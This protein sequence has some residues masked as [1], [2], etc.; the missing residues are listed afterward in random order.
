M[1]F[2]LE[3]ESFQ[4]ISITLGHCEMWVYNAWK[5]RIVIHIARAKGTNC[6]YGIYKTGSINPVHV[7]GSC[8]RDEAVFLWF[9]LFCCRQA[10]TDR[11]Y[12]WRKL[13][14]KRYN[15]N[16]MYVNSAYDCQTPWVSRAH[17]GSTANELWQFWSAYTEWTIPV[18]EVR[19]E[20]FNF[21]KPYKCGNRDL[22]S[23]KGCQRMGRSRN[24][25]FTEPLDDATINIIDIFTEVLPQKYKTRRKNILI[26]RTIWATQGL[27][28]SIIVEWEWLTG[29]SG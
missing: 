9:S 28:G 21:L 15:W 26:S 12:E 20:L 3:Q 4:T 1:Q 17:C 22:E 13:W 19:Y 27:T 11:W 6:W 29:F 10:T 24:R 16:C 5:T 18:L 8:D 7:L 23:P 2:W 25:R 14:T